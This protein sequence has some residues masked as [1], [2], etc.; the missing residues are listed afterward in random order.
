MTKKKAAKKTT[1]KATK[2]ADVKPVEDEV[3][4]VSR[5]KLNVWD[6]F[7][8]ETTLARIGRW[9][10]N[11]EFAVS[12]APTA[13]DSKEQREFG[14][15]LQLGADTPEGQMLVAL[16]CVLDETGVLNSW[17]DLRRGIEAGCKYEKP[18]P[19]K[20]PAH[21]FGTNEDWLPF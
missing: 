5:Q 4:I 21:D 2:K 14:A 10:I 17:A 3:E 13:D 7:H 12:S 16:L 8:K 19:S 11:G 9:L 18:Q 20:K 1:K 6:D 15:T